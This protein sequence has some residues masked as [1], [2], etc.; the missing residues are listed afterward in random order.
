MNEAIQRIVVGVDRSVEGERALRTALSEALQ[1]GLPLTAVRAWSEAAAIGRTAGVLVPGALEQAEQQ[2]RHE[3]EEAVKE[4]RTQVPGA[5]GVDVDVHV[6]CGA[7]GPA[8]VAA[9]RDAEL[10][11]LGTRAAGALSRAVLG[12]VAEHAVHHAHC[13]VLVVRA[14]GSPGVTPARVLVGV[15]HSPTS[16]RA[17]AW[18]AETAA[19]HGA[20][21]VPVLAREQD[22]AGAPSL[23][24]LEA[25]E[26][27]CLLEA[28]PAHPGL[29]VEPEVLAGKA[30][31]ALVAAARP[32]DLLVV[33]TRGRSAA[34]GALLGSTSTWAL[35]HA[36]CPV[37]VVHGS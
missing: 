18:A 16:L 6:V 17:L 35:R 25:V 33:G 23:T 26:R 5:D 36:S 27:H 29:Q 15:D 30:G 21:L 2:A 13:P 10:L 12:S 28:V 4:A 31:R 34:V 8:L 9:A 14:G 32:D 20:V 24:D 3:A 7:P 22:I 19:L 37:A 1:R 11:V